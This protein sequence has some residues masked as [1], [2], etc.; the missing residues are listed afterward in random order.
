VECTGG[1]ESPGVEWGPGTLLGGVEW[2]ESALGSESQVEELAPLSSALSE[3]DATSPEH[4]WFW[5]IS[6]A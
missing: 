3:E 4:T 6:L 1:T 2:T 5:L